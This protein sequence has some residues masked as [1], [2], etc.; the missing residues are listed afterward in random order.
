MT[1][2]SMI[3]ASLFLA[4][5]LS[6]AEAAKADCDEGFKSHMMKMTTYVPDTNPG[7]LAVAIRKSL[8]AYDSCKAGDELAPY[9]LWNGI[10]D[11]MKKK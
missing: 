2:L 6:S 9:G 8:D 10:I 3:A 5:G 11:G 1:R 4:F 7:D